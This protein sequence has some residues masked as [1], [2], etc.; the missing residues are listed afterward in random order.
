MFAYEVLP[1]LLDSCQDICKDMYKIHRYF[2]GLQFALISLSA[3]ITAVITLERLVCIA[4][5]ME[6]GYFFLPQYLH[7]ILG[8]IF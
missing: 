2:V 5:P 7:I 6:V 4:L 3:W 8:F 1:Q